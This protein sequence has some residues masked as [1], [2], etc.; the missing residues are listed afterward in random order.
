MNASELSKELF[1]KPKHGYD[2]LDAQELT[3]LNA[4]AEEYKKF[5]N[6]GRTERECVNIAVKM[7]EEAGFVEYLWNPVPKFIVMFATSPCCW[8]SW[9]NS[10]WMQAA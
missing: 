3:L 10:L 5:L 9:V 6:D 1:Y 7:A 8:Q 2:L 4:Y